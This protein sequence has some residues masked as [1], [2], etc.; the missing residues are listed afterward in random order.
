MTCILTIL[1][2]LY[3]ILYYYG[4]T[5]IKWLHWLEYNKLQVIVIIVGFGNISMINLNRYLM[6]SMVP[7]RCT[8][9]NVCAC[10]CM[11]RQQFIKQNSPY[12]A[13]PHPVIIGLLCLKSS[14]ELVYTTTTVIFFFLLFFFRILYP[15][16]NN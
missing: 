2:I 9:C 6:F 4:I 3:Y 7:R 8:K 5:T 12:L 10:A 15:I 11:K 16:K 14:P 13:T 1:C